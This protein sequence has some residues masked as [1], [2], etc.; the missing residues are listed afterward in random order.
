MSKLLAHIA[1]R[2]VVHRH[3]RRRNDE[4]EYPLESHSNGNSALELIF[5]VDEKI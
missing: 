2:H 4:I 3:K 1:Q 5:F